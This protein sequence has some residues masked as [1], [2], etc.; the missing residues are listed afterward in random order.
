MSKDFFTLVYMDLLKW[1][2]GFK[3]SLTNPIIA[4]KKFFSLIFP[5]IFII[6]PMLFS[7]NRNKGKIREFLTPEAFLSARACVTLIIFIVTCIII[8]KFCNDHTPGGFNINDVH[9]LFPSPIGEKT[10]LLYSMLRSAIIS[11]LTYIYLWIILLITGFKGMGINLYNMIFSSLMVIVLVVF[12]K[13]LGYLIYSLKIRFNL[14][15]SFRILGRIF[16]GILL[17]YIGVLAYRLYIT[18]F[19]FKEVFENL[20]IDKIFIISS[21]EKGITLPLSLS[22]IIPYK[23]LITL[24]VV[25]SLLIAGFLIFGVNYYEDVAE[26]VEGRNDIL[27]VTKSYKDMDTAAEGNY[28]K[29]KTSIKSKEFFGEWAFLWKQNLTSGKKNMTK[30]RIGMVLLMIGIG[31]ILSRILSGDKESVDKILLSIVGFMA[32]FQAN[33][34]AGESLKRELNNMYIYILPGSALKKIIAIVTQP[35]AL[36]IIYKSLMFLPLLI[37]LEGNKFLIILALLSSSMFSFIGI[38]KTLLIQLLIPRDVE[39]NDG[40]FIGTLINLM[41]LI[42]PIAVAVIGVKVLENTILAFIFVIISLAIEIIILLMVTD[43]IFNKLEY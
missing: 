43:K 6:I 8:Y 34:S 7:G 21:F 30:K 36:S 2:N 17:V 27:K 13:S 22:N 26:I 20:V 38:L 18:N 32:I 14:K 42:I 40:G 10:I 28:K 35:V 25:T 37:F 41:L 9:Y 15:N 33:S 4:I 23:E 16:I 3:Y 19:Q 5:L 1:K 11:I 29:V 12:F 39:I 31:Y 24:I